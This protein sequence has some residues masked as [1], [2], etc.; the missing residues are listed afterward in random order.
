MK[1]SLLKLEMHELTTQHSSSIIPFTCSIL[2]GKIRSN[3][4]PIEK[5]IHGMTVLPPLTLYV[6]FFQLSYITKLKSIRKR[7]RGAP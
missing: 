5:S 2:Y 1:E 3:L 7:I 4:P 6:R